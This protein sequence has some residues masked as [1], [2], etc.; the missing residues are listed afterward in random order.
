MLKVMWFLK[1]APHLSPA[2]FRAWWEQH[3]LDIIRHQGPYMS[4][5]QVNFRIADDHL[6][7]KAVPSDWDG[8]AEQWFPDAESFNAWYDRSDSPT[9][10]DTMAHTS[11]LERLVV[12]EVDMPFV[13]GKR[14]A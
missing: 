5:Y 10:A 9:R 13:P 11:R 7:G 12:D 8:V 6:A 14:S 3:A 1:R 2:E 4:R